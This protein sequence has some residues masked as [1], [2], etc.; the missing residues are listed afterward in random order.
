MQSPW[1]T[2][3]N[4][5][6]AM[7][8]GDPEIGVGDCRAE[9]DVVVIP[10]DCT[11]QIKGYALNMLLKKELTFGNVKVKVDL[12]VTD[13]DV[14]CVFEAA[15]NGNPHYSQFIMMDTPVMGVQQYCIMNK[16]VIQFYNDDLTDPWGNFNGLA[17]DI[18][19]EITTDDVHSKVNFCTDIKDAD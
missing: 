10:I 7:F 2:Y 14:G 3:N 19:R 9:D 1:V 16:E 6:K 18:M 15:F 17:E 5:L 13:Y 12:N 4:Y 8:A 11:N